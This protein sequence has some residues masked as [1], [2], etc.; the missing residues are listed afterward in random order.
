MNASDIFKNVSFDN[1]CCLH[2][3]LEGLKLVYFE[4]I[5]L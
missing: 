2:E 1:V 3:T 4:N 5:H